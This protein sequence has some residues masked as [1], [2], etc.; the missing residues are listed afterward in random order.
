[1]GSQLN[2]GT[3]IMMNISAAAQSRFSG[4]LLISSSARNSKSD[5]LFSLQHC[6]DLGSPKKGPLSIEDL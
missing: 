3:R 5:P 2:K 1:M 4:F 6:V